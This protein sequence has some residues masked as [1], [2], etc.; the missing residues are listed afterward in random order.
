MKK[1]VMIVDDHASLRQMLGL[2]LRQEGHFEVSGE[3]ANGLEALDLCDRCQPELV[4]LD[5]VLPQLCGIELLRRLRLRDPQTRVVVYSGTVNRTQIIKALERKPHGFVAKSEPLDTLR[6]ALRTVANGGIY[7]AAAA[8]A[9]LYHT[10]SNDCTELT[11]REA[12]VLQLVAEGW[13]SKE[14]AGRLRLAS[15]TVENHRANLMRK[16]DIHEVA[17][18]TRYAM[19][20]GFVVA[21]ETPAGLSLAAR[22]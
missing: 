22:Y 9:L 11:D 2:V 4:I 12:E 3:A 15:K 6:E 17:G 19:C 1:R 8:S 5:L 7:L 14:I 16:L 18:L 20:H 21:D 13:S 10:L